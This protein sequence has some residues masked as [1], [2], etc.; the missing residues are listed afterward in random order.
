MGFQES[1]PRLLSLYDFSLDLWSKWTLAVSFPLATTLPA[2]ILPFFVS[3]QTA[4]FD[5]TGEI[6]GNFYLLSHRHA[7][8]NREEGSR[9]SPGSIAL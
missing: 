4:Q 5:K 3:L 2:L 7:T 8:E 6:W 9:G 1:S